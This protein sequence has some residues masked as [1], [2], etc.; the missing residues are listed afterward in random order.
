MTKDN[1]ERDVKQH[2]IIILRR[3]FLQTEGIHIYFPSL[4]R[5]YWF[6]CG[7]SWRW[8]LLSCLHNIF[9]TH[10]WILTRFSWIC[11]LDITKNIRFWWPWHNFQGH[12]SRKTENWQWEGWVGVYF[13]E[14]SYLFSYYVL[15][16]LIRS[17]LYAFVENYLCDNRSNLVL[18]VSLICFKNLGKVLF[19]CNLL[20]VKFYNNNS[21]KTKT[22]QA[23]KTQLKNAYICW[24]CN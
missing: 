2:I 20:D 18:W 10:G 9:W 16:V 21:K 17:D 13:S 7:P 1:V 23:N 14:N 5:T 3:C 11:N 4:K 6:W 24:S 19:H 12:S 22:K 15:C 8:H